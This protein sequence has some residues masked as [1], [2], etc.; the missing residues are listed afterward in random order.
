MTV[1]EVRLFGDPVLRTPAEPVTDFDRPLRNLVRDLT[2]TLR[3][4]R[5]AGE[6]DGPEGCMSF[7]GLYFDVRRRRNVVARGF[8]GHGD[9]VQV[10]GT[11]EMARC[12]QQETDH[13]DG[14]LFID[15][16]DPATRKA[17]MSRARRRLAGD[18]HQGQPASDVRPAALGRAG[19]SS[20]ASPAGRAA[21]ASG[22]T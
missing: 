15:R 3:T 12:L 14:V 17:A 8:T 11:D 7:P 4:E 22:G 19:R 20:P 9:P 2:E 10:V 6:R 13:L 16:M 21:P 5:G 18:G 1:R